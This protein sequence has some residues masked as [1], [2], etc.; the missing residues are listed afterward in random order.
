[1]VR[2]GNIIFYGNMGE[3]YYTMLQI[4]DTN[5]YKD[6]MV[7]GKV[8]DQ[9]LLTDKSVPAKDALIKKTEKQG[10]YQAMDLATVWI[11]MA[12]KEDEMKEA[13]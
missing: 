2:M 9:L 6:L 5:E 4:L 1:M 11:D 7:S 13:K 12:I 10:L 8:E 3:K